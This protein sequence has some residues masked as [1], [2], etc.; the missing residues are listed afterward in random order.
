MIT[1]RGRDRE[2]GKGMGNGKIEGGRKN[3][4]DFMESIR[5]ERDTNGERM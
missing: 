1:D 3:E 4:E 2:R 5:N